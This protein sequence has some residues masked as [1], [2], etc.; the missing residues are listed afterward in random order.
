[1]KKKKLLV[2]LL[3]VAMLSLTAFAFVG[4]LGDGDGETEMQRW[5]RSRLHFT[6][7]TEWTAVQ[8]SRPSAANESFLFSAHGGSAEVLAVLFPTASQAINYE[9][10]F[11]AVAPSGSATT[12]SG[13]VFLG[14]SNTAF[15]NYVRDIFNNVDPAPALPEAPPPG[16]GGIGG[17]TP[18]LSQ[19]DAPTGVIINHTGNALNLNWNA[20]TF[21]TMSTRYNV[22]VNGVF[23]DH[24]TLTSLIFTSHIFTTETVTFQVRAVPQHGDANNFSQS[25]KSEVTAESTLTITPFGAPTNVRVVGAQLTWNVNMAN[26][27]PN[28]FRIYADGEFVMTHSTISVAV[29]ALGLPAGNHVITVVAMGRGPF[30]TSTPSVP[31]TLTIAA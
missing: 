16:S 30:S 12:S 10:A 19:V 13:R 22:Y 1:M 8:H 21:G 26:V 3:I 23:H 31:F 6:T 28:Q 14:A 7:S 20:V 18:T 17:G 4:C 2:T 11:I 15:L 5:N 27:I 29:T 25:E 9:A 24:T